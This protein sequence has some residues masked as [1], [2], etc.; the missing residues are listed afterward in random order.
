MRRISM[1]YAQ[2]GIVLGTDVYDNY[3]N[4]LFPQGTRLTY[5]NVDALARMGGGELFFEDRRVDDVPVTPVMPARLEGDGARKLRSLI[6]VTR[7]VALY[8]SDLSRIDTTELEKIMYCMVQQLFPA[9]IGEVNAIGCFSIKDYDYVHPVQVAG[10]SILMGRKLGFKENDLTNLGM[11]ALFE[12]IGYVALPAGMMNEPDTLDTITMHEVRQHCQYGYQI[13]KDFFTLSTDI[14]TAVFN[15]HEQWDGKGYP[16]GL[17]GDAIAPFA[18]II[19]I[20][21]VYYALVSR[22]PYRKHFL[23]HE[24]IEFIMA[25]SGEVFEPELV[26]LFTRLVPLYPTGVMV[27][28]NTGERCI[29]SN[30]NPGFIGRPVVRVCYDKNFTEV[31]HPYDLDLADGE[32]QHRLVTD[33]VEY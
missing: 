9:A 22:R 8:N 21:D 18:R 13:L 26:K 4:I 6:E 7:N 32:H 27:N 5:D 15:H 11:A 17:K 3:G 2:P 28:I 14:L 33:V 20:A 12:N 31:S 23:P 16:Q 19:S 30:A 1:Q 29:I 25:F 24:A 10:L